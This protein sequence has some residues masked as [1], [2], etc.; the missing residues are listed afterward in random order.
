MVAR[1]GRKHS[2]TETGACGGLS[3]TVLKI[4]L[5]NQLLILVKRFYRIIFV[6]GSSGK[7]ALGWD[8]RLRRFVRREVHA[9]SWCTMSRT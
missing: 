1:Y 8:S 9:Q 2:K 7:I 4:Y 6:G 3:F 5:Q